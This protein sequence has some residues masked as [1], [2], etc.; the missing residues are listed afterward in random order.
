MRAYRY[1]LNLKAR[2]LW[3]LVCCPKVFRG[4]GLGQK[5]NSAFSDT[6]TIS[7]FSSTAFQN[8][9]VCA[10]EI[11]RR[12]NGHAFMHC[13]LEIDMLQVVCL[14]V[15]R[16]RCKYFSSRLCAQVCACMFT[17]VCGCESV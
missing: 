10:G 5:V 8:L 14:Q 2:F 9:C 15:Q 16:L 11:K 6:L 7:K 3:L 12:V 4:C 17:P 1:V 13:H